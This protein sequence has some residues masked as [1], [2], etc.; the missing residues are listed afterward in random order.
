MSY[1]SFIEQA[2]VLFPN[3]KLLKGILAK[4]QFCSK[5]QA[6]QLVLKLLQR[7]ELDNYLPV[8]NALSLA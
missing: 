1:S 3:M 2:E 7:F 5:S 6:S 8:L 4:K